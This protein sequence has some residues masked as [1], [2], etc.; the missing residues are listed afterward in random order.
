M[1]RRFDFEAGRTV[2]AVGER[3]TIVGLTHGTG[4]NHTNMIVGDDPVFLQHLAVFR[5]PVSKIA[6]NQLGVSQPILFHPKIF[7]FHWRAR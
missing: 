5:L 1:R 7:Q 4:G 2:N 6:K 3:E